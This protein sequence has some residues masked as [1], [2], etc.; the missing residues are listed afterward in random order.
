MFYNNYLFDL[1]ISFVSPAGHLTELFDSLPLSA[2]IA[3]PGRLGAP[4]GTVGFANGARP[5]L[6]LIR[7][8]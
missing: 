8:Y 5:R 1:V 4:Q 6:E 3:L 7:S 2:S